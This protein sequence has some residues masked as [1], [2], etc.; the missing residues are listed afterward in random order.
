MRL[1]NRV[2]EKLNGDALDPDT[3][4]RALVGSDAV[5]QILGAPSTPKQIL[6]GTR[7]LSAATRVLVDAMEVNAVKRLICVTGRGAGD[8]RGHGGPLYN[9]ALCPRSVICASQ[10]S[11]VAL[12]RL[13]KD[14]LN[15]RPESIVFLSRPLLHLTTAESRGKTFCAERLAALLALGSRELSTVSVNQLMRLGNL[16]SRCLFHFC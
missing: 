13:T 16:P 5:I 4:Q 10:Y 9:A 15:L 6:S 8:S 2:L 7:L 12:P 3:I 14:S 1:D 11:A